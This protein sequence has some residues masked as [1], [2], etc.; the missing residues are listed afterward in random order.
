MNDTP[1]YIRKKQHEIWMAKPVAERFRLG[2]ELIDEVNQQIK[3]RIR[4]EHPAFTEGECMAEFIR[5]MYKDDLSPHYLHDVMEWM[6][7]TH[8]KKNYS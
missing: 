6:K 5:Q 8:G 3:D 1:D 7:K 4:R 2:L